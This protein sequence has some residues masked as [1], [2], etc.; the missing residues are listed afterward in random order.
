VSSELVKRAPQ[1][2][3]PVGEEWAACKEIAEIWVASGMLPSHIKTPAQALATMLAARDF[4][5]KHTAA[6]KGLWIMN[7]KVQMEA[8]VML[9]LVIGRLPTFEYRI[10]EQTDA[11]CILEGRRDSSK[12]WLRASFNAKD[13]LRAGLL[14]R[15]PTYKTYP[16]DMYFSKAAER[17]CRRVAPDI[18][19][20]ICYDKEEMEVIGTPSP[21]GSVQIDKEDIAD[22]SATHEEIVD[23]EI[24]SP[25][26]PIKEAK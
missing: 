19:L 8:Q 26:E 4:G 5:I 23:A 6:F 14:D 12:P 11:G 24:V 13:A 10:I 9:G 16:V 25:N 20:G 17:L 15:N 2:L 22:I 7:G 1:S 21:A 18:L 3:V